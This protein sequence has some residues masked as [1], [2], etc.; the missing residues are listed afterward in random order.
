MTEQL[1][2][3]KRT[4]LE[5]VKEFHRIC[6]INGLRYVL[7]FGTMIGCVRHHG[8]IPWDDDIDVS[9]PWEDYCRFNEIAN[10]ATDERYM[11]FND[12]TVP[13]YF[14]PFAKFVKKQSCAIVE[15]PFVRNFHQPIYIDIFPAL[16]VPKSY[17]KYRLIQASNFFLGQTVKMKYS[18]LIK[19]T[20][21]GAIARA[22]MFFFYCLNRIVPR[23]VGYSLPLKIASTVKREDACSYYIGNMYSVDTIRRFQMPLDVFEERVLMKFEDTE[24]YMPKDYDTI[25]RR[26]YGDYMQFPPECE[27]RSHGFKFVSDVISCSEYDR[28]QKDQQLN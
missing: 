17:C 18:G 22:G 3:L 25:L 2:I 15:Y 24:L 5:L 27:R 8:F 21:R 9:M 7:T 20:R 11:V 19:H 6:E 26:I 14:W 1:E 10:S 16:Y 23:N 13:N 28:Q 12:E 4:E